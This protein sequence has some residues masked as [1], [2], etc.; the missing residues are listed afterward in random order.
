MGAF[1]GLHRKEPALGIP[2]QGVVFWVVGLGNHSAGG[3]HNRNRFRY[4]WVSA[5]Y[6]HHFMTRVQDEGN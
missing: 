3:W 5:A 2:F 4:N 1:I 6:R